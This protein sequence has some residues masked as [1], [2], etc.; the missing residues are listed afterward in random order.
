ML[1]K[2]PVL[3]KSKVLNKG[4]SWRMALDFSAPAEFISWNMHVR[5]NDDVEVSIPL[6][7]MNLTH[8][9]DRPRCRRTPTHQAMKPKK[10]P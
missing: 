1:E 8:G 7:Q 3:F 5:G 2:T 4:A 6:N 9:H 10:N